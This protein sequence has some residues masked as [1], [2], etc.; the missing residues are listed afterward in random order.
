MPLTKICPQCV[1]QGSDIE[2][3]TD[4]GKVVEDD[5][6]SSSEV[7]DSIFEAGGQLA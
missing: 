4:I 6:L 1:R 3:V 5:M 2:I 7:M